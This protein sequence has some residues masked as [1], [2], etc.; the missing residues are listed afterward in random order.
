MIGY[1]NS[2]FLR[3]NSGGAAID[4]NAQTFI[5]A[6][7]ITNPIQIQAVNELVFD[8]KDFLL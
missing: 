8:L 7:G 1:G 4:P 2:M 6:A 3:R 5:T